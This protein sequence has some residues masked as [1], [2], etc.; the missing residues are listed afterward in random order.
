[1]PKNFG[2]IKKQLIFTNLAVV[3]PLLLLYVILL[4]HVFRTSTQRVNQSQLDVLEERGVSIRENQEEMIRIL[5][6]LSADSEFNKVVSQKEKAEDYDYIENNRI[7]Q[8]KRLLVS[9]FFYNRQYLMMVLCSNGS[10]YYD[11]S[12]DYRKD[13]VTLADL[14]GEEW[15]R[16]LYGENT[17]EVCL[18]PAYRSEILS[19]LFSEDTLFAVQKLHNLNSGRDIGLLIL[20]ADQDTWVGSGLNSQEEDRETW[21]LDENGVLIYPSVSE[22]EAKKL[23]EDSDSGYITGSDGWFLKERDDGENIVYYS[24]VPG[25]G[26]ILMTSYPKQY[27]L[28]GY[29]LMVALLGLATMAV[30]A[31]VLIYNCNYIGRKIKGINENI[32]EVTGGNLHARIQGNYEREFRELCDNFNQM[33]DRI[34]ELM[35]QLEQKEREKYALEFQSLSLQINSHFLHN[36]LAAIRFMIEIGEYSDADRTLVAF[37]RLLRKSFSDSRSLISVGEELDMTTNYLELMS[38]RYQ[39]R[40]EWE[41]TAAVDKKRVGILK[42]TIQPL[43]ENSISHGFNVKQE[44]GHIRIRVYFEEPDLI[45]EIEDDGVEADLEKINSCI[46]RKGEEE[47]QR[48]LH[49]IGLSNV[50]QRLEHHFGSGYGLSAERNASGGVTFRVRMPKI[51]LAECVE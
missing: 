51:S 38:V 25:K 9:S 27:G 14:K 36:T 19:G 1:M 46:H 41:I 12:L 30:L 3:F 37:S 15:C 17:S 4:Q 47:K 42:N 33:L 10:N 21:I 13:T 24:D 28:P 16:Q 31:L 20:A 48:Q 49:S 50:Q 2:S 39:N 44:K 7:I 32:L 40:F 35:G 26:W 5:N 34:E 23:W 6:V 18:L 11:S 29:T 22:A 43:V 45:I 8:S